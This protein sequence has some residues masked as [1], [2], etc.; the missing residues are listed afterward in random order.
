MTQGVETVR[1]T[2]EKNDETPFFPERLALAYFAA[3]ACARGE[4]PPGELPQPR[5]REGKAE[6]YC[7]PPWR[8]ITWRSGE[9]YVSAKVAPRFSGHGVHG[10]DMEWTLRGAPCGELRGNSAVDARGGPRFAELKLGKL[11]IDFRDA[12]A[13]TFREALGDRDG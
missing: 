6:P 9:L 3:L 7:P 12:V 1:V 11:D 13:R 10:S 4:A 8:R 2:F 5:E